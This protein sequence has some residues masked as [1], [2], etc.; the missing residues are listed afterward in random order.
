MVQMVKPAMQNINALNNQVVWQSESARLTLPEVVSI[1]VL[2]K[3]I[4]QN[5]WLSLPVKQVCFKQVQKGDS[6]ILSL[7]LLWAQQSQSPVQIFDF[8]AQ[9]NPLIE[10]YDLH[11]VVDFK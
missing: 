9:F 11:T 2:P 1:D 3:L 7:I 5:R 8:P 10:L 6:A 4:K